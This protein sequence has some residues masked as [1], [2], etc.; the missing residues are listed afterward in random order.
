M[1]FRLSLPIMNTPPS[2]RAVVIIVAA[3]FDIEAQQD[4]IF[5]S[6]FVLEHSLTLDQTPHQ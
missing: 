2:R 3:V 6:P 1:F 5:P 4:T